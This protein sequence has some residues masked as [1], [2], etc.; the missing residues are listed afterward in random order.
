MS[1]VLVVDDDSTTRMVMRMILE[2]D[3]HFV[4]EAEHGEAALAHFPTLIPDIVTTDLTMPVLSGEALIQ[5]LRA[6]PRTASI[7]IVVVSGNP[8][9]AKALHESG[10][11]AAIVLKPFEAAELADCIRAIATRFTPMDRVS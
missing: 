7:P 4:V 10:I 5:R 1:T 6:E 8:A 3:G 2:K 9:A 11:V